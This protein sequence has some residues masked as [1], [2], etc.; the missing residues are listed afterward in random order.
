[1]LTIS[2][3]FAPITIKCGG[4]TPDYR[5]VYDTNRLHRSRRGSNCATVAGNSNG[6]TAVRDITCGQPGCNHENYKH[7]EAAFCYS[8]EE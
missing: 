8:V 1:M 2:W 3:H 5:D 4:T 6:N 7:N